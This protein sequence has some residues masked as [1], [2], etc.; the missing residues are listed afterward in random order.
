MSYPRVNRHVCSREQYPYQLTG[1]DTG[2]AELALRVFPALSAR[3]IMFLGILWVVIWVYS[4]YGRGVI[5]LSGRVGN[6]QDGEGGRAF[7][8]AMIWVEIAGDERVCRA[9]NVL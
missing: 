1:P 9:R 7:G 4:A 3:T 6:C 2:H 8:D 5:E